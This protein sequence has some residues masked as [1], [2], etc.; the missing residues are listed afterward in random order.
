ALFLT[1]R[2]L[3]AFRPPDALHT[4]VVDVPAFDTQQRRDLFIAITAV[5]Y[6]HADGVLRQCGFVVRD[7]FG[8]AVRSTALIQRTAGLPLRHAQHLPHMDNGFT[9]PL[10]RG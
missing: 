2:H 6:G 4:F 7:F 10:R 9:A 1:L 8:A 3:Q 5:F